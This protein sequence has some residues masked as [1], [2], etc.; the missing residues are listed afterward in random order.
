MI[1]FAQRCRAAAH[2]LLTPLLLSAALGLS[3]CGGVPCAEMV[4]K[5]IQLTEA[6]GSPAE[7]ATAALAKSQDGAQKGL[8]E[9]CNKLAARD[10]TFAAR[11]NCQAKA[12]DL[13]AFKACLAAPAVR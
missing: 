11:V 1:G 13:G 7:K 12:G 2:K 5:Q 6:E 3:A 8:V 9:V 10:A 4:E